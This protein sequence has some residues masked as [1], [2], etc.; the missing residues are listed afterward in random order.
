[1][2]IA[3][4][5]LRTSQLRAEVTPELHQRIRLRAVLERTSITALV[6]EALEERYG[7]GA[8]AAGEEKEKK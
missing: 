7:A 5:R 1:M 8:E 2:S 6:I 4:R 3:E